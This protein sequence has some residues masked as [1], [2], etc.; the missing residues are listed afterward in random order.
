METRSEIVGLAEVAELLGLSKPATVARTHSGEFPPPIA[1]LRAGPVWDRAD[2]V[3]YAAARSGR[4]E[5]RAGIARLA[6]EAAGEVLFS[7]P[8][9]VTTSVGAVAAHAT[10]GRLRGRQ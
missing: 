3:E 6:E 9:L 4:L 5:E 8:V 10:R 7:D 2:V 1:E